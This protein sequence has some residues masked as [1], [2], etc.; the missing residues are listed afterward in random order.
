MKHTIGSIYGGTPLQRLTSFDKINVETEWLSLPLL[1]ASFIF[2]KDFYSAKEA[3]KI[4]YLGSNIL[5]QYHQK[6]WEIET[7]F[8][9]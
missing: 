4:N 5:Y 2:N 9:N 3:V 6:A 8:S 1:K 7:E